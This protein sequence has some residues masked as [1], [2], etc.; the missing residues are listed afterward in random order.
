[1]STGDV[2]RKVRRLFGEFRRPPTDD[3]TLGNLRLPVGARGR[4]K[5][6]PTIQLNSRV[7]PEVKKRVRLLAARDGRSLSEIIIEAID[8]YEEKHGAAP[9]V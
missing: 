5:G 6:D 1:M 7:P 4:P 3:E 8:L 2:A 9:K